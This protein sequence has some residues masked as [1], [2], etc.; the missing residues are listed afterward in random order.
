MK[1][2]IELGVTL[3][4]NQCSY[5]PRTFYYGDKLNILIIV[6]A[7]EMGTYWSQ[8]VDAIRPELKVV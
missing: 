3:K 2:L 7:Y 5:V 1:F 6:Q 8:T 4:V